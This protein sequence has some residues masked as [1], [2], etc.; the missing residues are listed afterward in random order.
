MLPN[1]SFWKGRKGKW[2]AP[3]E[4]PTPVNTGFEKAPWIMA[5]SKTL[6]FSRIKPDGNTDFDLL[7]S[8][9]QN[10]GSWSELV[11]LDFIIKDV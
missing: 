6:I 4:L 2:K 10:D 11:S 8:A 1:L 9:L 7:K 3:F 5:D